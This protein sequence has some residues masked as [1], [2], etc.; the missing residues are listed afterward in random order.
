VHI[1][2]SRQ[3]PNK[4][5]NSDAH[6]NAYKHRQLIS[7]I[8]IKI[9]PTAAVSYFNHDIHRTIITRIEVPERA[10]MSAP[11]NKFQRAR[12]VIESLVQGVHPSSGKDL[13]KDSIINEIE[14]TRAL[15]TAVLAIDQISARLARRAQL[16]ESVGKAWTEDEERRLRAAFSRGEPI[17]DI[18]TRHGRTVRAIEVRLEK[19]GIP[20][21][22]GS[23]TSPPYMTSSDR[24][25]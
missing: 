11:K 15:S 17:P 12:V 1:P 20:T 14:V 23:R 9:F 8:L 7:N 10:P 21:P 13:P 24:K 19:L 2:R 25:K 22:A 18:A 6:H 16:P 4:T 3:T 5:S